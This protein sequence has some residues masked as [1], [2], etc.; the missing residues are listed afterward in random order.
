FVPA[1]VFAKGAAAVPALVQVMS[2]GVVVQPNCADAGR[3]VTTSKNRAGQKTQ[4]S[5]CPKPRTQRNK[6]IPPRNRHKKTSTQIP[7]GL[8]RFCHTTG[9]SGRQLRAFAAAQAALRQSLL[10][11]RL[12]C[13]GHAPNRAVPILGEQ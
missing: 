2:V 1:A 4:T 13:M 6:T 11:R 8:W 3:L 12:S 9:L 5:V 10:A 7:G